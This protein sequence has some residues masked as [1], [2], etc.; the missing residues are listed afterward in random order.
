MLPIMEELAPFLLFLHDG[1]LVFGCEEVDTHGNADKDPDDCGDANEAEEYVYDVADN[2]H[3]VGGA[4]NRM[5][6]ARDDEAHD[7]VHDHDEKQRGDW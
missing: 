4:V 1:R 5:I 7:C 3:G 2:D 6:D